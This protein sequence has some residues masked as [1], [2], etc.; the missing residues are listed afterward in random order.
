[1]SAQLHDTHVQALIRNSANGFAREPLGKGFK[2]LALHEFTDQNGCA[3]YWRIRLKHPMTGQKWIRPMC[4]IG[5]EFKLGEPKFAD[6]KP[7]YALHRVAQNHDAAIWVV[8]GEQKADAL[9]G[10][11]LTATTSGGATS[12]ATCDWKPLTGRTVRLWRDND[13]AGRGYESDVAKIL[14]GAGCA[15]SCVD[16]DKLGLGKNEDVIDWMAMH[17]EAT[18]ADISALPTIAPS[19][20]EKNATAA[21]VVVGLHDFLLSE[22]P[23]REQILSPWLLTQS[24]NMIYSWRGVGKTHVAL[25][26]AYAIAAGGTFLGWKAEKA[27]R[28]MYIDGEMPGSALQDRLAAIVAA[29]DL[30]PQ[31]G[32]LNIITPDLQSGAMPD[33]ATKEGQEAIN[34]V[35]GETEVIIID[36]LSCLARGGG[37][38]NEAE[39]WLVVADWALSMRAQGRSAVFLHHAGKG[40]AQRGTSKK[41]DLLDTVICLR[42]PCDY[43]PVDGAVF[44][45]SFDKARNLLGEQTDSFEAKLTTNKE[46][47]QAWTTRKVSASNYDRVV[48]LAQEGLTMPEISTE[49]GLNRSTVSRTVR[50][51]TEDGKII[52]LASRRGKNQHSKKDRHDD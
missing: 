21:L 12:A 17:P 32:M 43:S 31:Q 8:E 26:I 2:A 24:L 30:Q 20:A 40:G 14:V 37:R 28:V 4:R 50:R 19:L 5:R 51:A 36:N 18:A 47:I 1:M 33:L 34:S 41:E 10:L 38:E 13:E 16:V 29:S 27:R 9:N 52:N 39:S 42:H 49:L 46:G 35:L 15:V 45:I 22:L 48:A 7:L 11:G 6:G 25:G 44:E 3:L 23:P